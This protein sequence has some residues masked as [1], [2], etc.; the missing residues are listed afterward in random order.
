MIGHRFIAV[1]AALQD[2]L[3]FAV[4]VARFL[5]LA[6]NVPE[7]VAFMGEE[8]GPPLERTLIVGQASGVAPSGLYVRDNL[9]V[10]VVGLAHEVNGRAEHI[11]PMD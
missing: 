2:V 10:D 9:S 1:E 11:E 7:Y 4:A 6:D 8:V 5:E 3:E